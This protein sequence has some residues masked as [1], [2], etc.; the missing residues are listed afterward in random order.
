[1]DHSRR[2]SDE[3]LVTS[4][5]MGV[6]EARQDVVVVALFVSRSRCMVL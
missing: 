5:G 2:R 6:R 3:E 4:L 1:M